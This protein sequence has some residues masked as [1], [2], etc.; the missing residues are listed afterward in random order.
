MTDTLASGPLHLTGGTTNGQVDL[1]GPREEEE[2]EE[3]RVVKI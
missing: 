1:L 3:E 2:E